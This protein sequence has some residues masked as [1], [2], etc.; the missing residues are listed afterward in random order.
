MQTTR[1]RVILTIALSE[2]MSDVQV[3]QPNPDG[4]LK[5]SGEAICLRKSL[6]E[7]ADE[8]MSRSML[9]ESGLPL[10]ALVASLDTLNENRWSWSEVKSL[11]DALILAFDARLEHAVMVKSGILFLTM[12]PTRV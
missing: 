5:E 3:T 12:I 7:M 8:S 4:A 6:E 10:S 2:L 9:R 1:L 11:S